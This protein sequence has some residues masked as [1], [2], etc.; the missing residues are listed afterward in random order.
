LP[1]ATAAER[2]LPGSKRGG[3][4]CVT[5]IQKG[6]A[7]PWKHKAKVLLAF[8]ALCL[9]T[10]FSGIGFAAEPPGPAVQIFR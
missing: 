5:T 6:P 9:V 1:I 4:G 8:V 2:R 3:H 7:S 10:A